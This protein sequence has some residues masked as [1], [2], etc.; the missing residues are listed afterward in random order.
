LFDIGFNLVFGKLVD[1][2]GFT[3]SILILPVSMIVFYLLFYRLY[4]KAL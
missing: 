4:R 2:V 3:Y 1:N